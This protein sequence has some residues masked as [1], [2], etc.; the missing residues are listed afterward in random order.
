MLLFKVVEVLCT[1]SMRFDESIGRV[2]GLVIETCLQERSHDSVLLQGGSDR[3]S[4]LAEHQRASDGL[5]CRLFRAQDGRT[6]QLR[7]RPTVTGMTSLT[8]TV[9]R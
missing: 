7:V 6:A 5:Q 9:K 4:R 8:S 3:F 2:V 1:R